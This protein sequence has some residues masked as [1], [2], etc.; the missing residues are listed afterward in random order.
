MSDDVLLV[1]DQG[2]SNLS[3]ADLGTAVVDEI[4]NPVHRRRRFHVA[5]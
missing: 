3:G 4:E 5:Y 1:D 2:D